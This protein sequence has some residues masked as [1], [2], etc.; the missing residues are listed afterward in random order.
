[1]KIVVTGGSGFIGSHVVDALLEHGKE[2]VIYDLDAPKYGQK[3]AFVRGDVRDI[4]RMTQVL[5]AGRIT[6]KPLNV[7]KPGMRLIQFFSA[8]I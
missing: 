5:K 8:Y 7:L 6:G 1:M 3:C 2:V 4:D